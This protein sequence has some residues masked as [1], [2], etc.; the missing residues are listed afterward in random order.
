M[1]PLKFGLFKARSREYQ[2]QPSTENLLH[3]S[4]SADDV[5]APTSPIPSTS[6]GMMEDH[7]SLDLSLL[8]IDSDDEVTSQRATPTRRLSSSSSLDE[9][10]VLYRSLK[11]QST[12]LTSMSTLDYDDIE[13]AEPNIDIS[14]GAS[15]SC[16]ALSLQLDDSTYKN[17]VQCLKKPRKNKLINKDLKFRRDADMWHATNVEVMQNL[18]NRRGTLD[19]Q[20][21]WEAI[22]T[23][24]GLCTLTDN[25]TCAD[26]TAAKFL[27][28]M[29][30]G[31]GGLGAAPLFGAITM[32][33]QLL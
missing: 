29:A 10:H 8:Q 27:V 17:T 16:D 32:G 15:T 21:K 28:G 19:E 6:K 30:D 24:R 5:T 1:A 26:C 11:N 7:T 2:E 13:K 12:D 9:P 33:C 14:D 20:I 4:Q 25:C 31:D 3:T 22:A 23:A 18:L